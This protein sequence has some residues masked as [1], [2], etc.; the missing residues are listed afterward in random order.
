MRSPE[1]LR[2]AKTI[3]G[4]KERVNGDATV[5]TKSLFERRDQITSNWDDTV[6][7]VPLIQST[8][9]H[10]VRGVGKLAGEKKVQVTPRQGAAVEL[11]AR[12]A[13]IISTGSSAILP[14]KVQGLKEAD[15]WMARDATSSSEAPKHLIVMGGGVVGVEC[16]TA[17][18]SYGSKVSLICSSTEPLPRM[19][20]VAGKMVRQALEQRG[21][22]VLCKTRI[23][24]VDRPQSDRVVVELSTGDQLE[25][26]ELLVAAGRKANVEGIGLESVGVQGNGR[27]LTVDEHL[28]V[29]GVSGKWLYAAGDVNG[30][31]LLTHSSKYHAAV[32]A[33]A[34]LA[35]AK[36][37]EDDESKYAS[38][39]ASA[40]NFAVPQVI[41]TDPIVASVGLTC[42]TAAAKGVK[43]KEIN[44]TMAAPGYN[45]HSDEPADSWAQWLVDEQNRLV[46][47]TFVGSDAAELLHASTIAVVAGVKLEM[48]MHAIPS[49]PTLSWVYYNLMDAAGL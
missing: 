29:T 15:P 35:A 8:G 25:G 40:D 38:T 16:A 22:T 31:S 19:D 7:L 11:T 17:Y 37:E 36:G 45:V 33:N 2:S 44:T 27:F 23:T 4:A 20:P 32:A 5:D 49:F 39:S 34:I 6:G 13:V 3:R 18:S 21:V 14:G 48:L 41:F 10:M 1:V 9:V 26:T 46:G 30:R 43:V 24:K 47:A 42:A 28:R 12:H